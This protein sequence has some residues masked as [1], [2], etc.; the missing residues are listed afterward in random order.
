MSSERDRKHS[1]ADRQGES[2][3]DEVFKTRNQLAETLS[4]SLASLVSKKRAWENHSTSSGELPCVTGTASSSE[5]RGQHIT[6]GSSSEEMNNK[7]RKA[8]HNG[9]LGLPVPVNDQRERRSKHAA[10]VAHLLPPSSVDTTSASSSGET[11]KLQ[12]DQEIKPR[13]EPRLDAIRSTLHRVRKG[14]PQSSGPS[15]STGGDSPHQRKTKKRL[16]MRPATALAEKEDGGGS[17][18][19]NGGSSGSGTEGGYAGSASSNDPVHRNGSFSSPS[20]S[21]SDSNRARRHHARNDSRIDGSKRHLIRKK[22]SS[23]SVSSEVADYSSSLPTFNGGESEE[24]ITSSSNNDGSSDDQDEDSDEQAK[25]TQPREKSKK[26]VFLSR[27]LKKSQKIVVTKDDLDQKAKAVEPLELVSGRPPMMSLGCD[28]M[29]HVMTFLEPPD[30]LETLTAPVSKEWQSRFCRQP[31]LWRVLC[32]LDPFKAQVECHGDSSSDE[33]AMSD[34]SDT[35]T[36]LRVTFGKYRLLY[37]SFVRCMKYL[38]Q[39]KEDAVN[40]RAPTV[41]DFAGASSETSKDDIAS[42]QRLQDFLARARGVVRRAS[43]GDDRRD[44]RKGENTVASKQRYNENHIGVSD[45]GMTNKSRKRK[46]KSRDNGDK[47]PKLKF[48]SSMLTTRLLGPAASGQPGE[49]NLPWSCAIYSIVN[50]MASFADVEGIQIMCLKVLPLILENEQHRI[51]AQ[52]AGLTNIV[53]RGMVLFPHSSQLHTAAFHTVVL[54]ARPLGGQ[55]G[56]LFHTSMVN[57]S[58]IFES[59]PGGKGGK[60][61]IAVMLD[62]MRRFPDDAVLQAMSCWSLVNVA[63]EPSQKQVLVQLGGIEATAKAMSSHPLNAEV[64]VRLTTSFLG[65]F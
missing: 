55:E 22:Q 27:S 29:A 20:V 21:S 35:A 3:P 45:D 34:D 17:T 65:P 50:W 46:R 24:S 5:E 30:I 63:L 52:R 57:A 60:N 58:A 37:T 12:T 28:I 33:S 59:E 47:M 41:V 31:E 32:V 61:G 44:R 42:N 38:R 9:G 19:E 7:R 13:Q 8:S 39:I 54:L 64:Q 62:S 6:T 48:G 25:V 26:R 2:G 1:G 14:I 15:A 53:L 51:T 43:S 36:G 56:M 16:K 11:E 18:D 23:E 10:V 4:A 40:G 49:M